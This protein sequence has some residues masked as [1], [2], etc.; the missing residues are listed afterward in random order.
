V[1][2]DTASE[3]DTLEWLLGKSK[4][5]AGLALR[6]GFVHVPTTGGGPGPM[7]A[8]LRRSGALDL[9]LL[10]L[11]IAGRGSKTVE[12]P[13]AVWSRALGRG[14][15][16]PGELWASKTLSFIVDQGL[17]ESTHVGRVRQL[18]ALD[19]AGRRRR[20]Q[21]PKGKG[22]PYEWF[23][24]L[25]LA[26]WRQDWHK[27]LSMPAKA[28]LLVCLTRRP[29]F[30]LPQRQAAEWYGLSPETLG[31]GLQELQDY[32]LLAMR[33]ER[34]KAPGLRLGY[35][36]AHIYALTG[37]F[38]RRRPPAAAQPDVPVEA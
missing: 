13:L 18:R 17:L 5:R 29:E 23:L 22:G 2:E 34:K 11:L 9:Y 15:G 20:Y 24:R 7:R 10:V 8:F 27:Q 14:D 36:L 19:D 4:S 31:K 25:P 33:H 12:L 32:G 16:K 3:A 26:Y 38:Q 30:E 1:D 35:T 28:T 6:H 21:A 37:P